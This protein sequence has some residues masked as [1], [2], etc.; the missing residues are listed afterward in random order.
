MSN[1]FICI[2]DRIFCLWLASLL[3]FK[4]SVDRSLLNNAIYIPG[5]RSRASSCIIALVLI[6]HQCAPT[7]RV[8]FM[9]LLPGSFNRPAA[10]RRRSSRKIFLS[11]LSESRGIPPAVAGVLLVKSIIIKYQQI[12]I[13]LTTYYRILVGLFF[14]IINLIIFLPIMRIWLFRNCIDS[15]LRFYGTF[16]H[17]VLLSVFIL[18]DHLAHFSNHFELI[19][20]RML[21]YGF[22][23]HFTSMWNVRCT[24]ASCWWRR[25]FNRL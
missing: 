5:I 15:V 9:T 2:Y 16:K 23:S 13:K 10:A 6:L 21:K 24:V 14:Q 7:R 11:K 19:V 3:D 1:F 8:N 25:P 17:N 12:H 22:Q 18:C 20:W 4:W